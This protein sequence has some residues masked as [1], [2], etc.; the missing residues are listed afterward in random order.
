MFRNINALFFSGLL[1]IYFVRDIQSV[2]VSSDHQRKALDSKFQNYF[3]RHKLENIYDWK[4]KLLNFF[5]ELQKFID[6]VN[7][8]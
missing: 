5:Y 6:F 3:K 2:K 1:L 4:F 7:I 8:S